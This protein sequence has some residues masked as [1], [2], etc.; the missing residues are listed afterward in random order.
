MDHSYTEEEQGLKHTKKFDCI[1]TPLKRQLCL[2]QPQ[3][4]AIQ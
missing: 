1:C 2:I 4:T 3:F